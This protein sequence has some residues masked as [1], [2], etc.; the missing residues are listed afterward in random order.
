MTQKRRPDILNPARPTPFRIDGCLVLPALNRIERGEEVHQ[1]E[2]RVM[3]VLVC[4]AA[5]PGEVLS[6]QTLLDVVWAGSVVCEEALTRTISE[7]R[8]VFH[9]DTKTPRVIET[10]RKGG[11]RLIAPVTPVLSAAVEPGR[12]PEPGQE[13]SPESPAVP[14]PPQPPSPAPPPPLP[15]PL[16]TPRVDSSLPLTRGRLRT[17][18]LIGICSLAIVAVASLSVWGVRRITRA[19]RPT[20]VLTEPRPLTSYPGLELFPALSPDGSMIAFSWAGEKPAEDNPLDI[21]V[22]KVRNG[23]PARLTSLP[24]LEAFPSWSPDGTE[25]AFSSEAQE[26]HWICAVPVF[27]GEVR[28]M[29]AVDP[30]I[31]GLDWSPDGRT[32]AYSAADS[33]S[34]IPRIHLL[35]IESFSRRDLTSPMPHCQGD[36]EPA[37][38]PDGRSMAFI[39]INELQG[40]DAVVVP[41]GGGEERTLDLGGMRVSGVDWLSKKDLILSAASKIDYSL[42]RVAVASGRRTRLSIPGGRI[43]RVALSRAGRQLAFEKISYARNVWCVDIAGDGTYRRR[44]VPLIASTQRES[45]PVFSPDGRSIAFVSDRSGSPEVWIADSAGGHARRLTDH[46]ATQTTHP[47][48]SP[49]GTQI[50]YSCNSGGPSSIYVTDI[51]SRVARRLME[52]QDGPRMLAVWSRQGGDFYYQLDAPGGWEVWRVHPDGTGCRRISEA[53]YTII[54]ETSDGRGLLCLKSGEPGIWMLP[55]D[56]GPKSLVVPGERCRDWKET[57]AAKEGMYFTRRG[58]ET[59]T[60]G[61]YDFAT[62]RSDSLASLQW[63]A[64]SLALS[65]DRTMLLYDCIGELEIDLALAEISE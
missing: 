38:S 17:A 44:Q 64:A 45:E 18:G 52:G 49:D 28:R 37:F 46:Q 35:S 8:R 7:M 33:T 54:D 63:Y 3:Q 16:P 19:A 62:G 39:R 25:I 21:Y 57:I 56:G 4:L 29:A 43:Q 41:I 58:S 6:R 26:R 1:I 31:N 65:P 34:P 40:R 53:G 23:S 24:G 15:L 61:F 20:P 27:G 60:L 48:W 51:Q 14:E 10:I 42:W 5:R 12:A 47:R 50:A 22:M 59:S 32:I 36:T 2:P 30:P 55:V 13:T 11:Y 9:D